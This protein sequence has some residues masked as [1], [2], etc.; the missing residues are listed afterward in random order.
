MPIPLPSSETLPMPDASGSLFILL[1]SPLSWGSAVPCWNTALAAH[2]LPWMGIGFFRAAAPAW[3]LLLNCSYGLQSPDLPP[4]PGL[5]TGEGRWG[6]QFTPHPGE[7]LTHA[8]KGTR[9]GT[10]WEHPLPSPCVPVGDSSKAAGNKG[11]NEGVW[12]HCI[13]SRLLQRDPGCCSC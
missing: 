5:G 1:F 11:W 4:Q 2:S 12:L 7:A 10:G 3:E 6:L 8:P 13:C 9:A